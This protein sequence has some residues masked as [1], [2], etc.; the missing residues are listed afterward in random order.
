MFLKMI[1]HYYQSSLW[2]SHHCQYTMSLSNR[3]VILFFYDFFIQVKQKKSCYVKKFAKLRGRKVIS[4]YFPPD[5]SIRRN[6][7]TAVIAHIKA[8]SDFDK[9]Q[10]PM[11]QNSK[12]V[13][14]THLR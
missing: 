5:K 3:P 14:Y 1:I 13:S 7:L 8:S 6:P 10:T 2:L 12:S 11:V 9:R 4:W